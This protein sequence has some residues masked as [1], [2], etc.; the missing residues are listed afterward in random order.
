MVTVATKQR[1]RATARRRHSLRHNDAHV[2][3][4]SEGAGLVKCVSPEASPR[5]RGRRGVVGEPSGGLVLVSIVGCAVA[6]CVQH[7]ELAG[8]PRVS[9]ISAPRFGGMV[10]FGSRSGGRN[11]E[12]DHAAGDGGHDKQRA[13]I[14]IVGKVEAPGR[15]SGSY[16]VPFGRLHLSSSS[17]GLPVVTRIRWAVCDRAITDEAVRARGATR[18]CR[19]R[20]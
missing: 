18:R 7:G 1:A 3:V 4:I 2:F 19:G 6:R 15:F 14:L 11:Q 8:C 9:V 10:L 17:R 13:R 20:H 12:D 5:G 16:A